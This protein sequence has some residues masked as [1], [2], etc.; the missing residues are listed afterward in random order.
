[1]VCMDQQIQETYR[2]NRDHSWTFNGYTVSSY[3]LAWNAHYFIQVYGNLF[4][5]V[6]SHFA[7]QPHMLVTCNY[8][9]S[10]NAHSRGYGT[11]LPSGRLLYKGIDSME[12]IMPGNCMPNGTRPIFRDKLQHFDLTCPNDDFM[13]FLG[14]VET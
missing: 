1:M 13:Y 4:A 11:L 12:L 2:D 14:W 5:G 9:L 6:F 8:Y 7:K 10:N 3:A